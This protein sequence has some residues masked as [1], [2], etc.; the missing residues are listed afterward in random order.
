M[1][2]I[3]LSP[4]KPEKDVR[5]VLTH[6]WIHSFTV[7]LFLCQALCRAM[8]KQIKNQNGPLPGCESSVATLIL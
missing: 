5:V 6:G 8:A 7:H 3:L 2:L 1:D 4:E